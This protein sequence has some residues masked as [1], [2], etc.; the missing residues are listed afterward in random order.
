MP[1]IPESTR[2]SITLRIL[3]HAKEHWPQLGRLEV[4]CRGGFAYAAAV[5]PGDD[6]PRP[7][8][9]LRYGG[10]AHSLGFAVYSSATGRY[11]DTIRPAQRRRW[12]AST[13]ASGIPR[14]LDGAPRHALYT[15]VLLRLGKIYVSSPTARQDTRSCGHCKCGARLICVRLRVG[16]LE[17]QWLGVVFDYQLQSKRAIERGDLHG[18]AGRPQPAGRARCPARVS[19]AP[20]RSRALSTAG[21]GPRLPPSAAL[22]AALEAA[23]G[24]EDLYEGADTD[25]LVGIVR[26]W[27]AVESWAAAGKLAALRAMMREDGE[28]ATCCAAEPTCPTGGTTR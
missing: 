7:L 23:A 9:R 24:P 13:D 1:A 6:E 5:P 10:S 12:P 3:L 11:Q 20:S 14:F 22:A 18:M 26:Q 15:S 25:A 27:A 16:R 2:S 21:R 17:C 28:G 4:T 19:A 8:F